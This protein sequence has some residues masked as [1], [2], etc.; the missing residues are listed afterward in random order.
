MHKR[1]WLNPNRDDPNE[2][3]VMTPSAVAHEA[4]APS[5]V[6]TP[7]AEADLA[8]G[9]VRARRLPTRVNWTPPRTAF[10]TL[11]LG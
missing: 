6:K 5:T 2:T 3:D 4:V 8:P 11:D 10:A 7:L 1:L 9:G